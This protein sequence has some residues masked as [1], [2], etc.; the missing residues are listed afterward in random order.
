LPRVSATISSVLIRASEVPRSVFSAGLLAFFFRAALGL[1]NRRVIFGQLELDLGMRQ[2]TQSP[3]DLLRIVIC[4]LLVT[5]HP[6]TLTGKRNTSFAPPCPVLWRHRQPTLLRLFELVN[7]PVAIPTDGFEI[8]HLMRAS[9][10]PV[11]PVVDMK[12][13]VHA[14]TRAAS[15]GLLQRGKAMLAVHAGDQVAQSEALRQAL[16]RGNQILA[17]EGA[18]RH[19][20]YRVRKLTDFVAGQLLCSSSGH[21]GTRAS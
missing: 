18:D 13:F 14:A 8:R 2:E 9:M 4:P 10:R 19:R 5:S 1:A 11:A 12:P 7:H 21:R 17:A 15:I 20:G 16:R 6:N 3:A